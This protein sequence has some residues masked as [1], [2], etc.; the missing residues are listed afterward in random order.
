[1]KMNRPFL[2]ATGMILLL[3]TV[4]QAEPKQYLCAVEHAAGL[5]YSA[6]TGT[7]GP[8]AFSTSRKY[9]LRRLTSDDFDH[10]KGKWW[11]LLEPIEGD[12][13]PNWAFFEYGKPEP[14]PLATCVDG[15]V[16]RF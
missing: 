11:G 8:Q 4:A 1:M 3:A 16:R 9:V 5:H 13:K 7:W 10:N 15:T 2:T 14:M 6:E 12:P